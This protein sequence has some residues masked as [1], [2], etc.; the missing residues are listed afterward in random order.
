MIIFVKCL[1]GKLIKIE[2]E[3]NDTIENVKNK[4]QDKEGT[5]PDLQD[6][7]FA[8]KKLENEKKLEDYGICNESTLHMIFKKRGC[9]LPP[10][11]INYNG[12][13]TEMRICIC[14]GVKYLKEQIEKQF[15]IKPEFQVL[16]LNGE[17]L[18]DKNNKNI[19]K[20]LESY[21]KIELINTKQK[22]DLEN[23]D[24]DYKEIYKSEL[25]QL[26]EMGYNEEIINIEALKL[27]NG[28]IE[29]A[30]GYLIN[31]YN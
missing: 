25:A 4:V 6:Y 12:K 5:P 30:I 27:G 8:G 9:R 24:N 28:N 2:V 14:D 16:R 13:E 1:Y 23:D 10:I 26:K 21:S 19:L 17:I 31:M 20:D 18:E 7:I 3:P 11:Y 29:Y 22:E 15:G